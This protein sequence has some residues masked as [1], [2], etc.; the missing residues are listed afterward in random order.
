MV[1]SA[2]PAIAHL[3]NVS[4]SD[5]VVENHTVYYR[6]KFAAHLIPA[7]RS[8]LQKRLTHRDVIALEAEILEWIHDKL[9]VSTRGQACTPRIEDSMGPDHND[10]LTL[11]LAFECPHPPDTL[12]IE[13]D[14]FDGALDQYQNIVSFKSRT[15]NLGYVFTQDSRLLLVGESASEESVSAVRRFFVLGVEHILSG[16]DHLLF[17]LALLLPG[18]TMWQLG[19]IITAFTIAHSITLT[20][21]TLGLVSIP[22]APVEVAIAA[23]IVYVAAANLRSH[24]KDHR[25]RI[26]FL[27]GLIH[28]FGFASMLTAAGLPPENVFT[29]LLSFNLGV[30]AG[31][32]AVVLVTVPLIAW[33]VRTRASSR[34]QTIGS[35]VIIAAGLFWM[36]QRIGA[37]VSM[38]TG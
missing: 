5:I 25:R 4:Y 8:V 20:L 15:A 1:L 36:A 13:F 22:P 17:L 31:Q 12:R 28:G 32:L 16:Y 18:G 9:P 37:V 33:A 2:T 38:F 19:G 26:T 10:D 6:I 24:V 23:S 7:A 14:L 35:W 11:V 21:A 30:E 3:G 29:P 34:I 27:F